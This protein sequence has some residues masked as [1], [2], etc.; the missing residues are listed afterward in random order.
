MKP[1][2]RLY[3]PELWFPE[4]EGYTRDDERH[5]KEI[6]GRCPMRL[7][8]LEVAFT[9]SQDWGIWGGKTAKERTAIKRKRREAAKRGAAA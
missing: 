2:C 7:T 6:C 5:A 3:D 1:L 9:E 8:C 4:A